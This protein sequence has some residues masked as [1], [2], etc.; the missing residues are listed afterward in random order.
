M[1]SVAYDAVY[2]Q[3]IEEMSKGKLPWRKLWSGP[4]PQNAKTG[5]PYSGINF[6]MLSCSGYAD[7][8]WLTY[9]QAIEMGGQ[10]KSGEK[11]VKIVFWNIL[12]KEE[13]GKKKSIPLLKYF[14]IFNVEQ[15][16]GLNIEDI[17]NE[18]IL[19]ADEVINNFKDK[20]KITY[21]H[22]R[23]GYS[24]SQDTVLMP[25]KQQFVDIESY[26]N[27]L[28]HE[29]VHST[30]SESRL[31]RKTMVNS[32]RFGSDVYS[33]EELVA[34]FG[35]AFLC[36]ACGIDNTLKDSAAY[37]KGWMEAFKENPSMIVHAASKAQSAADYILGK[38]KS[39]D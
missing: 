35:A 9:K 32:E 1:K 8:R 10:V 3:I 30:G 23:A 2:N 11:S 13:N 38:T 5:R 16:E 39:I 15:I 14:N 18:T 36:S 19:S 25:S 21:G 20:P 17:Q 31:N 4:K 6:F 28:F 7:A 27:T 33:E 26:F 24:K 12:S 34:E 22:D 37:I 29:L